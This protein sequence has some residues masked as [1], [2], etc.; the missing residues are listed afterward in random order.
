MF[1]TRHTHHT[2]LVKY[3]VRFARVTKPK[4]HDPRLEV[5]VGPWQPPMA[6]LFIE[7][8]GYHFI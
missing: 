3:R 1:R 6:S 5:V 2:D 7:N 4:V 8:N